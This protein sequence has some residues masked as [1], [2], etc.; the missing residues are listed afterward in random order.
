MSLKFN[1]NPFEKMIPPAG[2]SAYAKILYRSLSEK[3]LDTYLIFR[4]GWSKSD[5][6]GHAGLLDYGTL[7]LL[8]LLELAALSLLKFINYRVS[9]LL[10]LSPVLIPVFIL[11]GISRFIIRPLC[12]AVLTLICSP[13]ILLVHVIVPAMAKQ[14]FQIASQLQV[15]DL[16]PEEFQRDETVPA[17]EQVRAE[18]VQQHRTALD[19]LQKRVDPT[20]SQTADLEMVCQDRRKRLQ[21]IEEGKRRL[22][23]PKPGI[24]SRIEIIQKRPTIALSQ[25]MHWTS[26]DESLSDPDSR[27][28]H[29]YDSEDCNGLYIFK[30]FESKPCFALSKN[31]QA[32]A[33]EQQRAYA[34]LHRLNFFGVA[35]QHER[36]KEPAVGEDLVYSILECPSVDDS[37]A[38]TAPRS[39]KWDWN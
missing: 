14:D 24:P 12:A 23:M 28:Y 5:P 16:A 4:G 25:A 22:R 38:E 1:L 37:Y 2:S 33:K 34:A 15:T 26:L 31:I 21:E 36:C 39:S 9:W 3:F 20:N 29:V 8:M 17:S 6:E 11:S 30:S 18:Y 13:F 32:E 27:R 19:N 7:G 35:E 10:L